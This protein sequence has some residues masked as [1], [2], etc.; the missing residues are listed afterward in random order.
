M[1]GAKRPGP[2]PDLKY[3]KKPKNY[4]VKRYLK[5]KK[6]NKKTDKALEIIDS[7]GPRKRKKHKDK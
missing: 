2:I 6:Y 7:V 4:K 3:I 5:S 1:S